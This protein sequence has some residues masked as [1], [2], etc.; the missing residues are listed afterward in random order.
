V[1]PPFAGFFAFGVFW[2]AWAAVLPAVKAG[3]GATDAQ[4]GVALLCVAAG[5]LTAMLVTGALADRFGPR[6]TAGAF[7]GFAA[8][9]CV[10]AF[11]RSV[12]ALGLSLLVLGAF[13]GAVDVT[14]NG[15]VANLERERGHRSLMN[16]AHALFPLG[17]LAGAGAAA[18]ARGAGAS[19][20][21][22]LVTIALLLL[23][24]GLA[25]LAADHPR[26]VAGATARFRLVRARALVVLGVVCA[27]GFM[28][29]NGLESWSAVQL[30]DTLGA[31]PAV[32]GLGPA[33]FAAAMIAGRLVIA[34]IAGRV[35]G[36]LLAAAALLSAA[37]LVVVAVAGSPAA[38]LAGVAVAGF[39]VAGVAP[40]VL[41]VGGRIAPEGERSAAI[42]TVTTVSYFGF[43]V[44]PVLVG[45]VAGAVGLRGGLA[46][47]AFVA[48]L[49]AALVGRVAVLRG[50]VAVEA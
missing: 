45:G 32:S 40:T 15:A 33:A 28:I 11:T 23:G 38:A 47:L 25:N 14:I 22:I 50:R 12:V 46:A 8:A 10:P 20:E 43:L 39:G 18:I 41:G 2:G 30:S 37:G 36:R 48:L 3:A 17:S 27:L 4:L 7:A 9:V 1:L 5:A 44:G 42:A 35:T 13:L 49:L 21:A 34:Q 29:E 6:A 26:V 19:A 16:Q 24:V 31:G